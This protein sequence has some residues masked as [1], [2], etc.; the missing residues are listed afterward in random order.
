MKKYY[1]I[2][3]DTAG[4]LKKLKKLEP[5]TNYFQEFYV[6]AE[7]NALFITI[8]F[9]HTDKVAKLLKAHVDD[10]YIMIEIGPYYTN[11]M[12]FKDYF[13]NNDPKGLLEKTNYYLQ[14]GEALQKNLDLDTIIDKINSTG[15]SSLTK[16]ESTFLES[17]REKIK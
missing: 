5:F 9:L 7:N 12:F 1:C 4:S 8:D 6:K 2:L 10:E 13:I 11:S 17:Y 16:Q 3:F 15:E 14:N